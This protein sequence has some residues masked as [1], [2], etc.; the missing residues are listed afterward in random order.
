MAQHGACGDRFPVRL[1]PL[2][3]ERWFP[4]G[5]RGTTRVTMG[6]HT[7]AQQMQWPKLEADLHTS[8][9]IIALMDDDACMFD[10]VM[11]S[12]IVTDEGRLVAKGSWHPKTLDH[13]ARWPFDSRVSNKGI[14]VYG[15]GFQFMV[16]FPVFVW[17]DMIV[18]YRTQIIRHAERRES[19][20]VGQPRKSFA[21]GHDLGAFWAAV[22]FLTMHFDWNPSEYAN[23]LGFAFSSPKWRDRYEWQI[24][25]WDGLDTW[26]ALSTAAHWRS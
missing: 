21:D 13:P 7:M 24:I 1:R 22:R 18:E 14:G 25:G 10:H 3:W 12:E 8:H 9:P 19:A 6:K 17:R 26:P 15:P 4:E 5:S 11:P 20:L 2:D 23:M 16:E